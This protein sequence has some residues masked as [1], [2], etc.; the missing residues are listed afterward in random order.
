MEKICT[1]VKNVKKKVRAEKKIS[2]K[3]LPQCFVFVL[4]RFEFDYDKMVKN[5]INNYCELPK[6]N[7]YDIIL[8]WCR[9]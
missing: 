6:K 5:K 9:S 3:D 7:R 8:R 1:F 2:I 4:N